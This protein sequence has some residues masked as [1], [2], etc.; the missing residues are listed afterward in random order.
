MSTKIYTKRKMLF[1]RNSRSQHKLLKLKLHN[2]TLK[3]RRIQKSILK[4]MN[5][6]TESIV[7]FHINCE[8]K[9][10]LS[11]V[12]FFKLLS[13]F[14]EILGNHQDIYVSREPRLLRKKRIEVLSCSSDV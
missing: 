7:V 12:I 1:Q 4:D 9:W 8:R 11:G 3:E 10:I 5:D 14:F 2:R 6:N 13:L